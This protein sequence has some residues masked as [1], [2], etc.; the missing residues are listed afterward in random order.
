M[1]RK[2]PGNYFEKR[3]VYSHWRHVD[4]DSADVT[5]A[6]N[7]VII[8]SYDKSAFS[9]QS[10]HGKADLRFYFLHLYSNVLTKKVTTK[11]ES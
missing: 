7:R 1:S 6:N 5:S 8:N 2:Y 9:F 10:L 3:W 11:L 4:K